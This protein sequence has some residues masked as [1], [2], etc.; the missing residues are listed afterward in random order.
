MTCKGETIKVGQSGNNV[1]TNG[2]EMNVADQ[3]FEVGILLAYD[4][5][6]AVLEELTC[7]AIAAVEGNDVPGQELAHEES[8]TQGTASEEE[9]GMIREK[10]PRIARSFR[11]RKQR[12]ETIN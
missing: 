6:V 8:D 1:R 9:M 3:F 12:C 7:P 11:L 2:V 5:F 10:S 4:G